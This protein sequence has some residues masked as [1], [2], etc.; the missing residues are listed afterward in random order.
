MI[1]IKDKKDCCGCTACIS[2]C[3]HQV[4]SMC[5]DAEGFLYPIVDKNKCIDCGL[6][7]KVCPLLNQ[8]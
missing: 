4:V 8:R 5:T 1:S 7:N 6:C 2:V 3:P